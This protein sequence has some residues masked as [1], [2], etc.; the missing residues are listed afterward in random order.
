MIDFLHIIFKDYNVAED[1]FWHADALTI[2]HF[3]YIAL[4]AVAII[5]AA[6]GLHF[7]NEKT[8]KYV[9]DALPIAVIVLYI[10]DLFVRPIA[11]LEI[12][13]GAYFMQSIDGY[14]DK[15]PFHICTSMGVVA[16]FAQ[17]SKL[18]Q[19]F[20][21]PFVIL[22]IVGPLM[23]ITYPSGV[24]GD[25]FPFCYNTIQTMLFHGLLMAWGVLSITTGQTR[26]TIKNWYKTLA[27]QAILFG[28][29]LL[30]N[31]TFSNMKN[32]QTW[33][34]TGHDWFFMKSGAWFIPDAVGTTWFAIIA[35]LGVFVAIYLV[36]LGV[37]GCAHLGYFI[38]SKTNNSKSNKNEMAEQKE[39]INV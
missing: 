19:R 26:V 33:V 22:S 31:I 30:G 15:L 29:A 32:A 14:L 28:W 36:A 13:D 35:P 6:I 2:W 39:T 20:K 21:G 34:D 8:K 16:V 3:V 9:L 10:F 11:Q 12:V 4:I 23:Y 25:R 38:A 37:Y 17:H 24:F 5:G 27:I 18:L 7:A 1:S